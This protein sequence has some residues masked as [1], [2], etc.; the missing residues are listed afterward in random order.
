MTGK[1][2]SLPKSMEPLASSNSELASGL[3]GETTRQTL[4]VHWLMPGITP[5]LGPEPLK[6]LLDLSS[7]FICA[8]TLSGECHAFNDGWTRCFSSGGDARHTLEQRITEIGLETLLAQGTPSGVSH[9]RLAQTSVS[10]WQTDLDGNPRWVTWRL[11]FDEELGLLLLIG[12]DKTAAKNSQLDEEKL[13]EDFDSNYRDVVV[14]ICQA[15]LDRRLLRVNEGFCRMTGYSA[16]ELEG[17]PFADITHPDDV[18]LGDGQFELLLAGEINRFAIEKRYIRKDGRIFKAYLTL[19][20]VRDEQGT[21]KFFTA[22]V[23]ELTSRLEANKAL[24]KSEEYFRS[25]IDPNDRTYFTADRHGNILELSKN[26]GLTTGVGPEGLL[27]ERWQELIHPE[28]KERVVQVWTTSIAAGNRCECEYRI[29]VLHGRYEWV[30]SQVIPHRDASGEI[31]CWYGCTDHIQAQ[32]IAEDQLARLVEERTRELRTANEALIEARDAA[33]AASLAKS[34][35]LANMSHEIR[36]PMNGVIGI[37]SLLQE[38][39]LDPK[40]R[41]MVEI[42]CQS[43]NNLIKIIGDI[44][45]FS[46]LE[47]G[48][49]VLD[50]AP[51]DLLELVSDVTALFQ[52]HARSKHLNLRLDI[53]AGPIPAVICDELRMRQVLSNLISNAVKFTQAGSVLVTV[54]GHIVD[55]RFQLLLTIQDEGIGISAGAMASM[56]ESFTQGDGSSQRKY[57]GTG[58]GLAISKNLVDLMGGSLSAESEVGRG[59]TMSLKLDFDLA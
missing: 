31:L 22:A 5:R 26:A 45:D 11:E 3:T 54:D 13:R 29:R 37:A 6:R 47:A 17:T 15:G 50:Y 27:G 25:I 44:L 40:C 38:Q 1:Y 18:R 8:F 2:E 35:F 51:T 58:L 32:K 30:R 14:G 9:D 12:V 4:K 55:G 49:T 43:G 20:L 28:D 42:I 16:E 53:K 24:Q 41:A 39:D 36:T 23:A 7:D 19:T 10:R 34:Q 52:G 59:T 56:F 48:K 33:L 57:G 21:P 46:K